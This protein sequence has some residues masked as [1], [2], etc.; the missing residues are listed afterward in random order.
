MASQFKTTRHGG[1]LSMQSQVNQPQIQRAMYEL[2]IQ[3]IFSYSPQARGRI[4]RMNGMFQDR[5]RAELRLHKIT[6]LSDANQYLNQRFITAYAKQ[7]GVQAR[8]TPAVWCPWP[9]HQDILVFLCVKAYRFVAN[10]NTVS[11][12]EK[13]Y[14]LQP[15]PQPYHFVKAKIE[16]H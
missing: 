8:E 6:T 13:I 5:L 15:I 3:I 10:D 16:N 9:Q 12:Q 1:L 2:S 4:E 11:Y 14:Q 7:F